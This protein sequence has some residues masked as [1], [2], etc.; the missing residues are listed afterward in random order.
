MAGA[1]P[2]LNATP[3]G[4]HDTSTLTR[5]QH[6]HEQVV[7]WVE[8]RGAGVALGREVGD[9]GGHSAVVQHTPLCLCV[10]G[11]GI[12]GQQTQSGQGQNCCRSAVTHQPA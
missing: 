9:H 8:V 5:M 6:R 11:S 2:V 12:K 4:I 7:S 1:A 3:H 10:Q